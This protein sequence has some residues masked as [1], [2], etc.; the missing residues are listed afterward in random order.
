MPDLTLGNHRE[1]PL[2]NC[3]ITCQGTLPWERVLEATAD[4]RG[5][6]D[7][8]LEGGVEIGQGGLTQIFAT[9]GLSPS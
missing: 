2:M 7:G 3:P 1:S 8:M 9:R 4:L 6:F 5:Q